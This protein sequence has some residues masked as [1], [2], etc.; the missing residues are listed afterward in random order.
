MLSDEKAK[1][2]RSIH[3][4][5][6]SMTNLFPPPHPQLLTQLN[7]S[8]RFSLILSLTKHHRQI[9]SLV[10]VRFFAEPRLGHESCLLIYAINIENTLEETFSHFAHRLKWCCVSFS[11]L[12]GCLTWCD[13]WM[14][15]GDEM[16]MFIQEFFLSNGKSQR[17]KSTAEGRK[18]KTWTHLVNKSD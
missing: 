10:L 3:E 7:H 1:S 18:R 13:E 8:V 12:F 9:T 4:G 14:R 6:V 16:M 17:T 11:D 15:Y 2:E 5:L